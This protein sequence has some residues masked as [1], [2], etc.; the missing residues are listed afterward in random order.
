MSGE[1]KKF[2]QAP[3]A[4]PSLRNASRASHLVDWGEAGEPVEGAA[5]TS[6]V[7]LHRNPDG[8]SECGI[9]VCTPGTWRC[10]VERDEFCYFVEG[11]CTYTRDSGETIEIEPDTAAFFEKGWNGECTV[12]ETVRKAYMIN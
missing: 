6:G 2:S 8:T 3:A 12:H 9:W 11:R 4:T 7:L 10:R 5:R 1:E